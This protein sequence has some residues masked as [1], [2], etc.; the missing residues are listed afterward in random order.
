MVCRYKCYNPSQIEKVTGFND[1]LLL[2]C[3]GFNRVTQFVMLFQISP[4]I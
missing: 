1:V 3:K 2:I 4:K